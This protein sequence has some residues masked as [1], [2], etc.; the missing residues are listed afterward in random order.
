MSTAQNKATEQ[1]IVAEALNQG[2]LTVLDA[3]LTP[4]FVY[5]GPGG[6]EVKGI[7][8][9]K[10]FIAELR[11]ASPDIHVTITNIL[12]EG[13]LVATNTF[14]TF[15]ATAKPDTA[16]SKKKISMSGAILD[17]FQGSKIA[18]TWEHY[19]RLEIYQQ[20]GLVPTNPPAA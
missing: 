13:D 1:R 2:N 18:E 6:R 12:A 19:D 15:T 14:C 10:Q 5:H 17:R 16:P 7:K 20:M 8:E 4:D 9:Y 11:T 3:C